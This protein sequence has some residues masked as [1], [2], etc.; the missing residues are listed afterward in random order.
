MGMDYSLVV[1]LSCTFTRWVLIYDEIEFWLSL[2]K[3]LAILAYFILAILIDMG[4]VGGTFIGMRYWQNPGS[5]ADGI[6]GVAKAFVIAGT[7]Y[8][9]VETVGITAGECRNP[10]RT[11]SRAIKQMFWRIVVFY[12][13]M[14]FFIGLLIPYDSPRLLSVVSAGI[15]SIYVTS[16]NICYLG[17]TG[18][19]PKFL[20]IRN[21]RGVPWTAIKFLKPSHVKSYTSD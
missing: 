13:G 1:S 2:I 17:Q 9:G 19:A 21:K 8:A 12:L 14:I 3:I 18:Q 15:S 10:Q 4:V 7:L 5:F 16:R 11:V 20:G 6:N